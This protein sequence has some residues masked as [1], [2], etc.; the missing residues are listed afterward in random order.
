MRFLKTRLDGAWLIVSEPAKDERGFFTRLFCIQEFNAKNL[1]THFV[2]HSL[3]FSSKRGTLRGMH[4]QEPPHD[5]VKVVQCIKGVVFDVI[6]DIRP[7]SPTFLQWQGFELTADNLMQ[8]YVPA[9]FA[10]GFQTLSDDAEVHYLISTYYEP[11][12]ARGLRY[13]DPAFAIN[14]PLPIA[15]ISAKDE[16]WPEFRRNSLVQSEAQIRL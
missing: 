2:Q 4:F 13:N 6:I 14:W 15:A 11:S 1:E 10:H 16:T 9:G 7:E 3:S 12:A 5:E 8:L